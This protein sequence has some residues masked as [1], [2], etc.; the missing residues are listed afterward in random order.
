MPPP[1]DNEPMVNRVNIHGVLLI[2]FRMGSYIGHQTTGGD[3]QAS[4][5]NILDSFMNFIFFMPF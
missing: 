1:N 4:Q 5:P 2:I 3:L